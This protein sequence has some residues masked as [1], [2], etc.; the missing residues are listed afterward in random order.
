MKNLFI[1]MN[2]KPIA[3][4]RVYAKVT[5]QVVSGILLS[6]LVYWGSTRKFAEFYK[7]DAEIAEE[8]GLAV[9]EVKKAKKNL[10]SKEYVS[11]EKKSIPCKTYYTINVD[12]LIDDISKL[13]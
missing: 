9:W 4:Y 12:K 1:Q 13:E 8:T 2:E 11:I 7:T 3:Y 10:I 6:Q 5:G